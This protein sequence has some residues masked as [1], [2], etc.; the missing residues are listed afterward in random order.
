MVGDKVINVPS[1]LVKK[2]EEDLIKF[3]PNSENLFMKKSEEN[4][5]NQT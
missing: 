5:T 3:H 1:Y 2:D 4:E